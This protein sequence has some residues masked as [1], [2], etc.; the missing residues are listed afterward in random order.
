[1]R[2]N[3]AISKL[4]DVFAGLPSIGRKTAQRLTFHLIK[5]DYDYALNFANSIID[6]KKKIVLCKECFNFSELE[7]C[8][9]C[10]SEKRN[11]KV[12]CVVEDPADIIAIERTNEYFGLYHVLHGTLNP[13]EGKTPDDLKIKELIARLANVNEVIF[14]LNP[15]IQGE[16]TSLYISKFLK[17][18]DIK[19]S[20][21]AS[22]VPIGSSLEFTDDA[23]LAKAIEMRIIID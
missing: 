15:S 14:A 6:L 11:K 20:K 21:I 4:V 1:V 3:N 9:I 5:Q 7:L 8:P 18:L 17:Q 23:T 22:G 10:L 19:A 12:I 13:L 2:E 16:A